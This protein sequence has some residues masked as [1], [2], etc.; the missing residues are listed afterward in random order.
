MITDV[1]DRAALA[2]EVLADV[3]DPDEFREPDADAR[4]RA[5]KLSMP[6]LPGSGTS[7]MTRPHPWRL[8]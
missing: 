3:R 4:A 7:I 8:A 1:R 6:D 2:D 5:A